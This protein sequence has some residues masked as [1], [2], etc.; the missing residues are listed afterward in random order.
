MAVIVVLS[1]KSTITKS[2]V[3]GDTDQ[4]IL[5]RAVYQTLG[6]LVKNKNISSDYASGKLSS[7]FTELMDSLNV[8]FESGTAEDSI[9][10]LDEYLGNLGVTVDYHYSKD[11]V[12][13]PA[14]VS[15]DSQSVV[16]NLVD[17]DGNYIKD[18]E[19]FLVS[20][21]T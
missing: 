7:E 1:N 13:I 14:W 10:A 3:E 12:N 8:L 11:Q 5:S 18:G 20:L 19:D 6:S 9:I 2:L 15:V 17:Q 4:I 21:T 16:R